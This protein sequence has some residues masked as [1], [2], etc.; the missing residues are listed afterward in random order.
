MEKPTWEFSRKPYD[1]RERLFEFACVVV[2]RRGVAADDSPKELGGVSI[3]SCTGQKTDGT[4]V[5]TLVIR[6]AVPADAPGIAAVLQA[7]AEERIH[8]AIDRA[9]TVQEEENYLRS[10]TTR[11]VIHVATDATA[12]IVGVQILDRWSSLL[13]S[14]AHVAQVGTFVLPKWRNRRVGHQLWDLT[15][16]F[17]RS[18]GYR[19]AVIHVRGSN[20]AAQAFY[21]HLGFTEC[22]RLSRQVTIDGVDDDEVLMEMFL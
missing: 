9:W 12:R 17:A 14:M 5:T 20:T 6:Q 1:L 2:R 15:I 18:A 10:L 19:K 7:I 11:E 13:P 3:A 4:V 21:R 22:G 16:A 8:S